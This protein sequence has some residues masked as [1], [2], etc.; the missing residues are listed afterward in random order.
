VTDQ[1]RRWASHSFV[2]K[3]FASSRKETS[4]AHVW[5]VMKPAPYSSVAVGGT[6]SVVSG[7]SFRLREERRGEGDGDGMGEGRNGKQTDQAFS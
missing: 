6:W 7:Q 2:V 4:V 5:Q 1:A 3:A